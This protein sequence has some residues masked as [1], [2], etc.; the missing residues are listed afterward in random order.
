[1]TNTLTLTEKVH[2][3]TLADAMRYAE[4]DEKYLFCVDYLEISATQSRYDVFVEALE[5]KFDRMLEQGGDSGPFIVYEKESTRSMFWESYGGVKTFKTRAAAKAAMTREFKKADQHGGIEFSRADYAIADYAYFSEHI[6]KMR[7][8]RNLMTGEIQQERA[9]T[10][11]FL[12]VG[13][14]TYWHA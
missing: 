9:N 10:P 1:M 3:A 13:C 4:A 12:S 8:V 11:Y 6:E 7:D 14:E 2:A 5:S